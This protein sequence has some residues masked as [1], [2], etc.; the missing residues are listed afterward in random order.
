MNRHFSRLAVV[1]LCI[2][3]MMAGYSLAQITWANSYCVF[4]SCSNI[5]DWNYTYNDYC[6][7]NNP[8]SGY[9]CLRSSTPTTCTDDYNNGSMLCT[10]TFLASGNPCGFVKAFCK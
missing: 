10:G 9:I 3:A 4:T 8:P 2:I 6:V 1:A 5:Q 7:G